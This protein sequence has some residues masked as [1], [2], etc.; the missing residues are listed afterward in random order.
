MFRIQFLLSVALLLG[1]TT[2]CTGS[3]SIDLDDT[4]PE[5]LVDSDGDGEADAFDNCPERANPDQADADG[6][7][8]GDLCDNC[9]TVDNPDQLDTD[10]D[11]IGDACFCD[12]CAEDT[13]CWDHPGVGQ[14]CIAA[15][16]CPTDRQCGDNCCP[17]GSECVNGTCPLPDIWVEQD[18]LQDS[19]S[20]STKNIGPND[21]VLVEGCVDA[22]GT[23]TLLRFDTETPNTG[24][25]D[26]HFGRPTDNPD[27]FVW[28]ECHGHYHFDSYAWYDLRDS[29]GTIVATGHKQAFC[30]MDFNV[31]DDPISAGPSEYD[32]SYQGISAG[33]ADTYGAYL[34]CQWVDVTDVPPGTYELTVRLNTDR[35]V[36]EE[37]YDNNEATATVTI[38]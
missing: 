17:A 23:R 2:A 21:C 11:L 4:G 7:G 22:S 13:L 3:G 35:I 27:V 28:S 10:G 16:Q 31:H 24:A 25:G 19:L 34:D 33:W 8:L 15:E 6:D 36:A 37:D 38:E 9:P 14:Q 30:L 20:I 18:T 29:N 12:T 1:L 26:L 32:C 5:Q